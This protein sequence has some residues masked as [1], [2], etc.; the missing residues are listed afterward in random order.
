MS[1][2][3]ALGERLVEAAL[4]W[5]GWA[6]ANLN[7]SI[8][9]APNV[10]ILASKGSHKVNIQV[11]AS[12]PNSKSMLQLGYGGKGSVFNSK[13]GPLADC[14]AFVRIFDL[15]DHEIYIV[16][17][18]EAERV[19]M[20]TY[21]DWLSSPK[22]DGSERDQKCPA[23]IRFELNRNRPDVSNYKERWSHY[24]DAWHLLEQHTVS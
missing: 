15:F 19:A 4:I 2:I 9:M 12:G 24:K 1:R 17:I 13:D 3:G 14:V 8:Q 16:P 22:A 10:D 11:K 7:Q 6:P 5:H 18:A 21:K 23:V 20:E